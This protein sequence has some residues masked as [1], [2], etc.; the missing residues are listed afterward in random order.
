MAQRVPEP[1][2]GRT[3]VEVAADAVWALVED[4]LL[5]KSRD[6]VLRIAKVTGIPI[7][8]LREA[9]SR[10]ERGWWKPP[11]G[12][13]PIL[14]PLSASVTVAP[15]A[16]PP[17]APSSP[18]GIAVVT[19]EPIPEPT[20]VPIPIPA[21][22]LAEIKSKNAPHRPNTGPATA[23]RVAKKNPSPGM[24]T[25]S[26]CHETKPVVEFGFKNRMTGTRKSMCRL[27]MTSYQKERY[28]SVETT[29]KLGVI[30]R[31]IIAASDD[32]AYTDCPDC[33]TQMLPGEEAAAFD[34]TIRHLNCRTAALHREDRK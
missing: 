26:A 2:F 23:V 27:C 21:P 5:T 17:P 19:P 33:K 28:L 6:S 32:C 22:V 1:S 11:E 24:R 16:P 8:A 13:R 15:A 9:Q 30:M 4:G 29:Q 34:V 14:A 10:W 25:C 7:A 3:E 31:F 12:S 20:L 18:V